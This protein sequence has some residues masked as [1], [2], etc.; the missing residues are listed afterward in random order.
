MPQDIADAYLSVAQV[1]RIDK[2][3]VE[4]YCMPSIVLM[5]NAAR[6]AEAN[7]VQLYPP[8]KFLRVAVLV[9][10][11]N[12]GGDGLA[13]ARLLHNVGYRVRLLWAVGPDELKGDAAVNRDIVKAMGLPGELLRVDAESLDLALAE[14]AMRQ[15]D[16]AIDALLGTG[17]KGPARKPVAELIE[18][19]NN[20]PDLPVVA[21]DVPSGF[22]ADSGMPA[23]DGEGAAII[24]T[25][26]VTFA[27]N[28]IGYRQPGASHFTGRVVVGTIGAPPELLEMVR[29]A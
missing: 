16:L 14:A 8:L 26:T 24:A 2:L 17:L 23:G 12:N 10:A 28:K 9:G 27:A 22:D 6:S 13:L 21:L 20:Q 7:I 19:V 5:E 18:L 11:G 1:R 29:Q 15:A 4:R 3:A 25:T